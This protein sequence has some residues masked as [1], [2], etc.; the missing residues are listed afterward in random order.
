METKE[1]LCLFCFER[2]KDPVQLCCGHCIC[3]RCVDDA[4][5]FTEVSEAFT[6]DTDK[7]TKK[8]EKE[9]DS[10]DASKDEPRVKCPLCGAVT[11]AA[12]C[13]PDRLRR[14]V[15]ALEAQ[16]SAAAAA[17][18][19]EE[20]G[21]GG[22]KG[23]VCGFCGAAATAFCAF[24]GALCQ[25]HSDFLHVTGPMRG[26]EVRAL[27]AGGRGAVRAAAAAEL[28]CV[29]Q[30]EAADEGGLP[31]CRAHHKRV[32]MYCE[33]CNT[34]VC[35][36]CVLIGAHKGHACTGVLE[37]LAGTEARI[38]ALSAA[39]REGVPVCA[40]MRAGLAALEG[41]AAREHDEQRAAL[42]AH[43]AALRE[44]LAAKERAAEAQLEA[45]Y[46]AFGAGVGAQKR[47]LET[48][49]TRCTDYVARA[50]PAG[51]ACG[52]RLARY[53]LFRTLVE[54]QGALAVVAKT[55]V[56]DERSAVCRVCYNRCFEDPAFYVARAQPLFRFNACAR[57]TYA[58]RAGA[59]ET[60]HSVRSTI[61]TGAES[62]H[63]GSAFYDAVR[64]AVVSV[65]G[66]ED[67]CRTVMV[68]DVRGGVADARTV[69]HENA[70]PYRSHGQYPVYDGRQYAYFL[71]S[72]SGDNNRFGRL[73]LDTLRF[74][75]LPALADGS[76]R[77]F[78]S[79][80]VV[81]DRLYAVDDESRVVAYDIDARTWHQTPVVFD[82]SC[83]LLADPVADDD[84]LYAL[85][86][87]TRGLY[88]VDLAAGTRRHVADVPESFD[89]GQ[90]GE[91]LLVA[92][93]DLSRLL[94]ASLCNTWYCYDFERARWDR[95][96]AWAETRN[97]SAHLVIV[98]AGPTALYHIDEES[99][100]QTVDLS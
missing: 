89:L 46:D 33:K 6:P 45:V 97:G 67:N 24:C 53:T 15:A 75:E 82:G 59:L 55:A 90:N 28:A 35:M 37:A 78:C 49:G 29:Q 44:T 66:N 54:L 80:C 73:D 95:L 69:R 65:S 86:E 96:P 48:L 50:V 41:R 10:G 74:E 30:A 27:G 76:F 17:A 91:A 2:V 38:A 56:P 84:T 94:F 19:E 93:P 39:L 61:A 87:G 77:E 3:A 43:F 22:D 62:S 72:E 9:K 100:W 7:N 25:T 20:E 52:S 34:L 63:D 81:G 51:L 88:A 70:V 1:N 85:C 42:R 40:T 92:R 99:T 13:K 31:V 16:V 60:T 11:P 21:E 64:E 32:E 8:K 79:G 18:E 23:A 26:H 14:A 12:A 98:P 36:H 71:E 58:I 57:V 47:A 68:M 4:C 83:R 5:K